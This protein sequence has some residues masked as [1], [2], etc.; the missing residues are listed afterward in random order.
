MLDG[1]AV[2]GILS[3][4]TIVSSFVVSAVELS[5]QQISIK[6]IIVNTDE[7]KIESFFI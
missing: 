5:P 6:E 7:V 3:L 2:S 1:V 4:V